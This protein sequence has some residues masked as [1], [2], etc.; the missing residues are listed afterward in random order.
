MARTCSSG[1]DDMLDGREVLR[2]QP[3]MRDDYDPDHPG[4]PPVS[5]LEAAP[6]SQC[7]FDFPVPS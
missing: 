1:P 6:L 3:A 2:G 7:A 5:P 4:L